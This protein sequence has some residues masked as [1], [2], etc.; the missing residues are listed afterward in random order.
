MAAEEARSVAE[1]LR[2]VAEQA[3]ETLELIN[4]VNR[5]QR[6]ILSEMR[7][8]AEKFDQ[9]DESYQ[10]LVK[11]PGRKNRGV[12]G[13]RKSQSPDLS[14]PI[15]DRQAWRRWLEANH[16]SAPQA[17]LIIARKGAARPSL[18]LE[19]AVG[20]AL[21][22]GWIDG[23]Q[24]P[25]DHETYALR[26]SPRRPH[27]IWSVNNQRRVERLIQ[28]GRMTPAGLAKIAEA[29]ENG[30]WEA[31]AAREDVTS[32]PDDLVQALENADAWL[33]FDAWPASRKKQYFYW[34]ENAKRPET[35]EKR[36]RAIVEKAKQGE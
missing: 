27:S 25:I 13:E 6:E 11:N 21:C 18:L 29:K 23:A 17:W 19:D 15:A 24:K 3:R 2:I 34:L 32:V 33:A 35:R 16:A 36:I 12:Q 4:E 30:E 1:Q 14:L 31:A 28:E 7:E 9:V 20:E 5:E 22:F 10:A 26:F 8:S